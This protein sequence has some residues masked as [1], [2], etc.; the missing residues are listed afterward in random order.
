MGWYRWRISDYGPKFAGKFKTNLQLEVIKEILKL[1]NLGLGCHPIWWCMFGE[2]LWWSV[3][4]E[5]LWW[6]MFGETLY[7]LYGFNKEMKH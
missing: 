4:S 3:E 2:P 7:W 6:T 5:L 1:I